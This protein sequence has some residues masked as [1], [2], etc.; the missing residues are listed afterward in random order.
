MRAPV[1][2]GLPL[3]STRS[4]YSLVPGC[5]E[6]GR[7]PRAESCAGAWNEEQRHT[8]FL[9]CPQMLAGAELQEASCCGWPAGGVEGGV[10]L[11]RRHEPG[12]SHGVRGRPRVRHHHMLSRPCQDPAARA[13]RNLVLDA[14]ACRHLALHNRRSAEQAPK[15]STYRLEALVLEVALLAQLSPRLLE[16]AC[17]LPGKPRAAGHSRS[18]CA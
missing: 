16:Q 14:L 1:G 17:R 15:W 5:C 18:V 10:D 9:S 13:G 4:E 2:L 12:G 6:P 3:S 7:M 11:C 8:A